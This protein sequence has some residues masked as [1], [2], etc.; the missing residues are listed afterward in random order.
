MTHI[1]NPCCGRF[2][3]RGP[4]G[5]RFTAGEAR[6]SAAP[7]LFSPHRVRRNVREG[8]SGKGVLAP[9]V[10]ALVLCLTSYAAFGQ[11]SP[12]VEAAAKLTQSPSEN[13]PLEIRVQLQI[14]EG[15]QVYAGAD[16]FFEVAEEKSTNLGAMSVDVPETETVP[17]ILSEKPDATAEVFAGESV[18]TIRCPATAADG[19]PWSFAGYLRYQ[20][21]SDTLCFPPTKVPFA[22]EGVIGQAVDSGEGTVA[23]Q[24]EAAEAA[25]TN[26]KATVENFDTVARLSGY[27][28]SER[29]T[30]FLQD[31]L[32]G[33]ETQRGMFE[34]LGAYSVWLAVPLVLLGGFLLNL[35][36]CVLPMIP[37]N[38]A[39]IG[40]GAQAESRGRG[41]A[42]GALYGITIAVV[43]GALG[44][45]VALT[46]SMLDIFGSPWFNLAIAV[47]FVL[48]G[49][50]TL[51]VFNIDFS[52]FGSNVNIGKYRR[53]SWMLAVFMAGVSAL[54]AGACVAPVVIAVLLLAV[55]SYD[56]GNY[57][58]LLYP[59]LLGAGM[60]LPWPFAGAGMSFLP[61]PGSWMKYVK[62][63]F[64]IFIFGLAFYYGQLA[65]NQIRP[66]TDAAEPN[67]GDAAATSATELNWHTS[68]PAALAE[69][70]RT[71]RPVFVDFWATWCKNC[72]VM[73]N[74]TFQDESVRALLRDFVLLKY[75]AE[76][77]DA[78]DTKPVL[79]HFD[80]LGLPTY[81][82]LKPRS[83]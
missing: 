65:Y 51:G 58:G 32:A 9:L 79:D 21:C 47:L 26:W 19:E 41:L 17:D 30:R 3:Q 78:P 20:A 49:L 44:L 13:Q 67:G 83:T 61:K 4:G 37:I 68:L 35:T 34:K 48:L 60:G 29:F 2:Q 53:G 5:T 59:F 72:H 18:I 28:G 31:A 82:V 40:A 10:A 66:Y 33:K 36:P 52:S 80:V 22:F 16:H 50:A 27:V 54:L 23:G 69:S 70:N 8:V 81:V 7:P 63:V 25:G 46:G 62:I 12:R 43:Y 14:P 71:G 42:L 56:A 11:E 64:A 45:V 15:L 24:D 75:Q 39:I 55:D 38:L 74:T 1:A 6:P 77:P 73:E 57:L 76:E